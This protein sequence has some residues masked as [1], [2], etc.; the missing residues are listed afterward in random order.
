M[1]RGLF[2]VSPS[3][4]VA[5]SVALFEICALVHRNLS[6]R[7]WGGEMWRV[8]SGQRGGSRQLTAGTLASKLVNCFMLLY[9]HIRLRDL[10]EYI[11][12]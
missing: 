3:G 2:D 4:D 6:E 8:G 1:F 7:G 12:L 5:L 10:R 9:H 11:E